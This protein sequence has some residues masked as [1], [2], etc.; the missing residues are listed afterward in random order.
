[1]D[2]SFFDLDDNFEVCDR[3]FGAI[4]DV[5]GDDLDAGREPIVCL[6]VSL[7]WHTSGLIGNGGIE[8]FV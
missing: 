7:V 2:L 8:S 6:T 5:T 1:M 3:A 4:A